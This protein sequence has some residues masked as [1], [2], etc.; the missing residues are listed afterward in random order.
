MQYDWKKQLAKYMRGRETLKLAVVFVDVRREPQ[1]ID[2]QYLEFL[3]K[4]RLRTLV[5]ATKTDTLSKKQ[6]DESLDRLQKG[7][8]LP[9]GQPIPLSSKTNDGRPEVWRAITDMATR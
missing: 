7:L 6:L 1:D 9:D 2:I 4:A 3:R 8:A 5:V